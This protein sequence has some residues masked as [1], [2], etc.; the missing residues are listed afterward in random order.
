[1]PCRTLPYPS[2]TADMGLTCSPSLLSERFLDG[3]PDLLQRRPG[4]IIAVLG[5]ST[6][7]TEIHGRQEV[8]QQ[9]VE[10]HPAALRLQNLLPQLSTL[11]EGLILRS[12][13]QQQR[14]DAD[15]GDT[16]HT[17]FVERRW[18]QH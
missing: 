11:P 8:N 7:E 5:Q 2:R 14:C 18:V 1:M 15:H 10:M 3:Q 4:S 16:A 9:A 6:R 13:H 12:C 17:Q